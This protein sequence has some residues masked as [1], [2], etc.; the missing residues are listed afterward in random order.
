[1]NFPC[2]VDFRSV[3]GTRASYLT[4]PGSAVP[5]RR[6]V[7]AEHGVVNATV[8]S[9]IDG[10]S[11][12]GKGD[13]CLPIERTMLTRI[14]TTKNV[15]LCR[16][17]EKL[18]AFSATTKGHTRVRDEF[19]LAIAALTASFVRADEKADGLSRTRIGDSRR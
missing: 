6:A 15:S 19:D 2:S 14:A 12:I 5:L 13:L 18:N 7:V 4:Q 11:G 17:N 10:V 1:M 8:Y 9:R 3:L 16:A